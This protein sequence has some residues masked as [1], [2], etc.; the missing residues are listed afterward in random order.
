[1]SDSSIFLDTQPRRSQSQRIQTFNNIK[2]VGA[3]IFA[4]SFCTTS[5]IYANSLIS[6]NSQKPA[7][8]ISDSYGGSGLSSL[9]SAYNVSTLQSWYGCT[10]MNNKNDNMSILNSFL[11]LKENWD[12]NGAPP[13][14]I[15]LVSRMYALINILHHQPELSP[16]ARSSIQFEY[17]KDNGDYLEFEMFESGKIAAF[18]LGAGGN[19]KILDVSYDN[20]QKI[21][22][23]V[24]S[25][26]DG[27]LC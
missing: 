20:P 5:N 21:N 18:F 16:T 3:T 19:S 25:F 23:V 9:E 8:I 7:I 2:L 14:P 15:S 27:T 26:Y 6:Q 22:E 24:D 12:F 1:M 13:I 10:D 11:S 4:I 17:D